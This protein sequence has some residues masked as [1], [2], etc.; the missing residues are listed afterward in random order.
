MA[1]FAKAS[2]IA[3][4]TPET[5]GKTVAWL[6]APRSKGG[7]GGLGLSAADAV[8]V[9][10]W[11]PNFYTFTA[12]TLRRNLAAILRRCPLGEV[13]LRTFM[14]GPGA[15][16]L[17]RSS[18][19]I[20]GRMDMLADALLGLGPEGLARIVCYA[21]NTF[22]LAEGKLA[23]RSDSLL[24]YGERISA[25]VGRPPRF[26][27]GHPG[28]HPEPGSVPCWASCAACGRG[29]LGSA[30][31]LPR[32]A[33][34][35]PVLL[36][37]A[38][39]RSS[40]PRWPGNTGSCSSPTLR[41]Q[42]RRCWQRWRACLAGGR[43]WSGRPSPTAACWA[44]RWT[45]WSAMWPSCGRW[46]SRSWRSSSLQPSGRACSRWTTGPRSSAPSCATL[47]TSWATRPATC[48]CTT[49]ATW[50]TPCAAPTA[51]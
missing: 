17:G 43:A 30:V 38:S 21:G 4:V 1:A 18:S 5:L 31:E 23:G 42:W 2:L 9:W 6:T 14:R 33:L 47:S 51:G 11:Q 19:D 41:G 46:G 29:E 50:A 27:G 22:N 12:A 8:D 44:W 32:T 26:G 13:Q 3:A 10:R 36:P 39:R 40:W 37:Q 48:S 35:P 24:A 20:V 15:T 28:R 34:R 7:G 16:L 49:P 45:P 25:W